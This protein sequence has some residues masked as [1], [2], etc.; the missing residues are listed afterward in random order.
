MWKG[1]HPRSIWRELESN[2]IPGEID[3]LVAG[4]QSLAGE[5]EEFPVPSLSKRGLVKSGLNEFLG[6]KQVI[7]GFRAGLLSEQG[8]RMG[9]RI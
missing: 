9:I 7:L 8:T 5:E 6:T 1:P 2:F 3:W 4:L